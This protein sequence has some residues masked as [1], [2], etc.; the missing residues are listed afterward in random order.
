[1]KKEQFSP[2]HK[3]TKS[4]V[5]AGKEAASKAVRHSKALDLTI[6]Y[7]E[8][9]F[10]YEENAQGIKTAIKILEK[11]EPTISL[12]KGMVLHAK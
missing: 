8:N 7:I 2:D 9:G 4:L 3:Q 6:T 5:A 10:V 1:M 11:K 12:T